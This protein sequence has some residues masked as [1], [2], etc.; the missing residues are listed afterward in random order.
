MGKL[1]HNLNAL[2]GKAGEIDG[3]KDVIATFADGS[4][5]SVN[6][7]A[8]MASDSTSDDDLRQMVENWQMVQEE[9]NK[10]AEALAD[11]KVDFKERMDGIAEDMNNTIEKMNLSNEAKTAAEETIRAY[12]DA[13]AAGKGS[14]VEAAD[15]VAA[16]VG[17]ALGIASA[18]DN[19]TPAGGDF[20]TIGKYADGTDYA[21]SGYALVGEEGPELV[22]FGGGEKVYPNDKTMAILGDS[23]RNSGGGQTVVNISPQF[24]INGNA[25]IGMIEEASE[26]LVELVRDALRNE[27]IDARRG[28]YV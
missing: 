6:V 13:I 18:S 28:A 5:D 27:G 15:I 14:V 7:I 16:A 2:L 12:A 17:N 25:D 4:S 20:N 3:L 8:G 23:G 24:T 19:K 10:T 22:K 26:R 1:Q 9:Q 11:T 21:K